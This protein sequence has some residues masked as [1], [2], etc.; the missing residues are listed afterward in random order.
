M[1]NEIGLVSLAI[2]IERIQLIWDNLEQ[3]RSITTHT[4]YTYIDIFA[5]LWTSYN[6]S[7]SKNSKRIGLP[8]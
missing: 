5:K 2:C 3:G 7:N 8:K 1:L 4:K 6:H